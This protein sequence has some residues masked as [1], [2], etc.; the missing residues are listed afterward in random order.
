[1]A[2]EDIS[3]QIEEL[4]E[5]GRTVYSI[6]RLNTFN[7]CPLQYYFT[8]VLHDRGDNN[9]YGIMGGHIHDCLQ[10]IC[11]GVGTYEDM[12]NTYRLELNKC[13]IQG[14]KFPS[15]TIGQSW[16]N[17]MEHFCTNFKSPYNTTA[18]E[19]GFVANIGGVHM[20]GFIDLIVPVADG[21]AIIDWKTSSKFDKKKLL[22]AGRQLVLYKLAVEKELGIPVKN[23]G[24]YMLKYV[25]VCYDKKEKICN[26]GKWVKDVSNL[27]TTQLKKMGYAEFMIPL[28]VDGAIKKNSLDNM[29]QEVQ[30]RFVLKDCIIEYDVTDVLIK[31][32]ENYIKNTVHDI[33]NA[34][35]YP[36]C[37]ID[38]ENFFCNTLCSH[39]DKCQPFKEWYEKNK[40]SFKKKY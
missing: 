20:Q 36:T 1:M 32:T 17:D 7:Q 30:D 10:N 18:T 37:D 39:K 16:E 26:R 6:S 4:K 21:V 25:K 11:D 31:E 3:K 23:V 28:M 15:E 34:I 2:K 38:K 24:W 35:E 19:K 13:K 33:E 22:Y 14:I 40:D 12:I 27:I 29:P 8:Y 5:K 9:I